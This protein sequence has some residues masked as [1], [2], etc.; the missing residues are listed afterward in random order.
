MKRDINFL[1]KNTKIQETIGQN[2]AVE[3][4]HLSSKQVK[5]KL[6]SSFEWL[7]WE[8]NPTGQAA[9]DKF[10]DLTYSFLNRN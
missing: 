8:K 3:L 5:Q 10:L 6:W 7:N 1:Q 9:A 2:Q 4:D